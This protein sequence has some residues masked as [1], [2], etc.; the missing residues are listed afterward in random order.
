MKYTILVMILVVLAAVLTGNAQTSEIPAQIE[1]PNGTQQTA[2]IKLHAVTLDAATSIERALVKRKIKPTAELIALA[3]SEHRD[4]NSPQPVLLPGLDTGSF[5]L[6][7]DQLLQVVLYP[8]AKRALRTA[9][10][11]LR[12]VKTEMLPAET[13]QAIRKLRYVNGKV[14]RQRCY[15]TEAFISELTSR[16]ILLRHIA[17]KQLNTEQLS[18]DEQNVFKDIN[19]QTGQLAEQLQ[20]R[21]GDNDV[22]T[23]GHRKVAVELKK[24]D[25]SPLEGVH[26][27]SQAEGHYD[28]VRWGLIK[29]A[30][31]GVEPFGYTNPARNEIGLTWGMK[32]YFIV[33]KPPTGFIIDDVA[34]LIPSGNG[35]FT[36][37]IRARDN[38]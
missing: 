35:L 21:L 9:T 11:E 24:S 17:E 2:G 37:E 33:Q 27:L 31:Y 16:S 3:K 34:H 12:A 28:L 1:L 8:E 5:K 26:V 14:L 32:W 6:S 30:D 10:K 22:L 38:K 13:R 19:S 7:K 4:T 25:G 29:S 18:T 36:V 20:E 15:M 23:R